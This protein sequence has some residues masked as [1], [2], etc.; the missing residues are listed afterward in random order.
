M[1]SSIGVL[2]A[3][4]L[5]TVSR[6]FAAEIEYDILGK[7]TRDHFEGLYPRRRLKSCRDG[8]TKSRPV[9]HLEYDGAPEMQLLRRHVDR[10]LAYR[11]QSPLDANPIA[12]EKFRNMIAY[13]AGEDGMRD[14]AAHKNLTAKVCAG[15]VKI[16]SADLILHLLWCSND[17]PYKKPD[18]KAWLTQDLVVHDKLSVALAAGEYETVSGLF[19]KDMSLK[20]YSPVMFRPITIALVTRDGQLLRRFLCYMLSEK[21]LN[22]EY[23]L[24]LN[25]ADLDPWDDLGLDVSA[26][27]S[28]AIL[29]NNLEEFQTLLAFHQKHIPAITRALWNEWI[30]TAIIQDRFDGTTVLIIK[31]LLNYK[32]SDGTTL[33]LSRQTL[34]LVLKR[35]N[36]LVMD[37]VLAF[38]GPDIDAGSIIALPIFIAVRAG[39]SN[40]IN[41]VLDAGANVDITAPSNMPTLRG[42]VTPLEVAIH[43]NDPEVIEILTNRGASIPHSSRWPTKKHTYNLLC[44]IVMKK[45]KARLPT[46]QKFLSMDEK[47]RK[48]LKH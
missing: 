37:E 4:K 9:C 43:R 48:D 30:E 21:V 18:F 42:S 40:A 32:P 20:T 1:I 23:F 5:R 19:A 34:V 17:G 3:W 13:I 2:A 6:M 46:L 22:P 10:Y 16:Y 36:R 38:L 26:G 31:T 11:L 27:I 39:S 33:R 15:L 41:V 7:R 24:S 25:D 45:S 12:L 35:A 28:D 8:F 47:T 14:L 44:S 29:T